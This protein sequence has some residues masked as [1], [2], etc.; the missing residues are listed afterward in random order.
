MSNPPREGKTIETAEA[1]SPVSETT[2]GSC[3]EAEM[4]D[5]TTNDSNNDSTNDSTIEDEEVNPEDTLD[6]LLDK[7]SILRD[8]I[9][10]ERWKAR[11]QE[12]LVKN[13]ISDLSYTKDKNTTAHSSGSNT[14]N[15][16]PSNDNLQNNGFQVVSHKRKFSA[17][18]K[19]PSPEPI[20]IKNRFDPIRN[21]YTTPPS[22]THPNPPKLT[23]SQPITSTKKPKIPSIKV[24]YTKTWP[25][26]LNGIIKNASLPPVCQ[27][28]GPSVIL[29]KNQTL[30]DYVKCLRHLKTI[31][32]EYFTYQ[33]PEMRN[34][35][36]VIR[37]LPSNTD[38]EIIKEALLAENVP[39]II[40]TEH[41]SDP[42]IIKNISSL[43][44]LRITIND[45]IKAKEPVQCMRC[46]RIGHTKNFCR[47]A[48]NCIKFG[49]P[50]STTECKKQKED[51]PRCYN[52]HQ[53]H[54]ASYRGCVAFTTAKQA[55][56]S[57]A[58]PTTS[59]THQSQF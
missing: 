45:Y 38:T 7:L 6:H 19:N 22:A 57:Q 14:N 50:H 26:I 40:T 44:H 48:Y 1:K 59:P 32:C 17:V 4:E 53:N 15:V 52:C 11:L 36:F 21:T 5:I 10:E 58:R 34:M 51:Q 56:Q 27:L 47:M 49:G 43:F 35:D 31:Q 9:P 8:R 33:V 24:T 2:S 46:Q 42:S 13:K 3:S 41:L 28:A 39:V 54:P 30:D 37:N 25:T 55:L 12:H 20:P 16:L 23:P 29:I 18:N